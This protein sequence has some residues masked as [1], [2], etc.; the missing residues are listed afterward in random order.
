[1]TDISFEKKEI[2]YLILSLQQW[3]QNLVQ[4]M[5]DEAG[6]E[7]EDLLMIDYLLEKIRREE[8]NQA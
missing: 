7:Y 2:T 3:R 5:G 6:D 8:K 4:H 1:M